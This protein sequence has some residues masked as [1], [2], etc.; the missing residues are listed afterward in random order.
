LQFNAEPHK[1]AGH[2]QTEA[3]E[4]ILTEKMLL[5]AVELEAPQSG[6]LT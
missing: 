2:Q 6:R 5:K 1:G 4:R 3:A